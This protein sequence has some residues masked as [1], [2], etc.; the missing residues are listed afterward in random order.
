[1]LTQCQL[2]DKQ[3]VLLPVITAGGTARSNPSGAVWC[4]GGRRRPWA[5]PGATAGS[6]CPSLTAAG[7][8]TL[9]AWTCFHWIIKQQHTPRELRG[10]GGKG[11]TWAFGLDRLNSVADH[12]KTTTPVVNK[13][14]CLSLPEQS[15]S[16]SIFS[17]T[18]C[19]AVPSSVQ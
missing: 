14:Q 8:K 10:G 3:A 15:S 16:T 19:T 5:S 11:N 1:M 9:V 18:L 2:A 12:Y 13:L 6:L 17:K 4:Q 7:R